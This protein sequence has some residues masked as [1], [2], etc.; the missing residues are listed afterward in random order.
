MI[1]LSYMFVVSGQSATPKVVAAILALA[2]I[3]FAVIGL[4]GPRRNLVRGPLFISISIIIFAVTV[5]PLGLVIASYLSCVAV[6]AAATEGR[7]L[8]TIIWSAVLNTFFVVFFPFPLH[9]SVL[10]LPTNLIR[11]SLL[12][13][14]LC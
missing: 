6:S 5:R 3:V 8:E 7:G 2:G 1:S 10:L 9:L 11:A 4:M 13:L 12:Y 14:S